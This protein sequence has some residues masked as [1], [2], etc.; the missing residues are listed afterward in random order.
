MSLHK[1]PGCDAQLPRNILACR[2]HWYSLPADLRREINRTW[3][4]GD[5]DQYLSARREAV[6]LLDPQAER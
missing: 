3:K 5:L 4:S 2:Q 6:A 1:C